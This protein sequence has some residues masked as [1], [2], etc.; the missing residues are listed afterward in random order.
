VY[1]APG[2]RDEITVWIK[3]SKQKLRK[4]FLMMYL[5]EAYNIF[6]NTHPSVQVSFSTFA[7]LRPKNVLLLKCQPPD[8]CK[9]RTHENF[10][11][12]LKSLNKHYSDEFCLCKNEEWD[13]DCWKGTCKICDGVKEIFEMEKE[14][15]LGQDIKLKELFEKFKVCYTQNFKFG[16][17]SFLFPDRHTS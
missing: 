17:N 16:A 4:Y 5:K 13:S 3:G 1:T 9:C 2:L 8:Q 10:F 6:K 11:N 15:D 12:K 7:D 14:K